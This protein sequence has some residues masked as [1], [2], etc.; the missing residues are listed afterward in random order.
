MSDKV[1]EN[2]SWQCPVHPAFGRLNRC[3]WPECAHG[4]K[5]SS[6]V[7]PSM[8]PTGPDRVFHRARWLSQ[9]GD[10]YYQWRTG[11]L[12]SWFGIGQPF[13]YFSNKIKESVKLDQMFHYTSANGALAILQSGRMRFTD[14]AYLND[15]REITYGLDVIRSIM[16]DEKHI[17]GSRALTELKAHLEEIDPFSAYRIY[18]TSFSTD[19]DSLSQFRLYGPLALGFEINPSSFGFFK[20]DSHCDHVVYDP[21]KQAQLIETFLYLL[22]QSEEKDAALVKSDKKKQVT[23]DYLTSHLLQIVAF[24]KH[25]AFSDEREIRL[26]YSEPLE[27]MGQFGQK[28]AKRQFRASGG[29]I[30]PFTD[31]FDM[32]HPND[33]SG[34]SSKLPLK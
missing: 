6:L 24:F 3:A 11:E 29:L 5:E 2:F 26:I 13:S 33:G 1:Y 10:E 16:E 34:V 12:P 19:R 7:V 14:Y 17:T 30:V 32:S 4:V 28:I 18:T 9:N 15:T 23:T 20:G 25:S 27:V 21:D 22:R 8:L 31:T